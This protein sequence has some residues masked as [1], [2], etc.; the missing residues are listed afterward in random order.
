MELFIRALD[1]EDDTVDEVVDEVVPEAEA[2]VCMYYY[3]DGGCRYQGCA[4]SH[5]E[6]Q[7]RK[8][9]DVKSL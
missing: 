7:H 6:A 9:R 8:R 5:A 3:A 1:T 4:H 2:S